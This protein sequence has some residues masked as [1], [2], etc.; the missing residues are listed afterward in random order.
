[1]Q[2]TE[3]LNKDETLFSFEVLPPLKGKSIDSLFKAIDPLMEC[4]PAFVDV[5]YHREEYILKERPDGGYDKISKRKRPGTVA[6]CAALKNK[7]QVE[8]VPHL[9]CGGFS[10]DDTENAL[11]DLNFLGIQNVLAIR[12]D[13]QKDERN[14]TPEPNGNANAL[15][16]I[17]QIDDMNK[18]IYLDKELENSTQTNF[19]IGAAGY[20]EKHID[21]PNMSSDMRF[22]KQKVDAGAEFITTQMFFDNKKYFEYV[23]NCRAAGI[24]VPIIP[25][26]KPIT[27]KAH[28]YALP[29]IFN[30]D[31]PDDLASALENA[32]DDKTAR[33][34]GIEWCIDQCKELKKANVPVLHFYT[35]SFSSATKEIVSKIF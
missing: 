16:L 17:R 4:K 23:E 3:Y 11:I 14:F 24:H 27:K 26:I 22:L 12:G 6:I 15:E 18:G 8:T 21:A 33:Q 32:K 5:T 25:G 19:C 35:M 29:K 28:M 30:I 9:I 7:Y 13:N 1:M 2:L 31:L 20:P 10:K 34:I